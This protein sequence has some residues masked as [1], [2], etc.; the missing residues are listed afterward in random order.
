L[1]REAE[2][3]RAQ[4]ERLGVGRCRPERGDVRAGEQQPVRPSASASWRTRPAGHEDEPAGCSARATDAT[5]AK[6][7]RRPRS[8]RPRPR[9]IPG[10]ATTAGRQAIPATTIGP[11]ELDRTEEERARRGAAG[12]AVRRRRRRRRRRRPRSSEVGAHGGHQSA[13]EAH[14][15][16]AVRA[17]GEGRPQGHGARGGA[18]R[19]ARA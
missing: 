1:Q 5:P 4:I 3:V 18:P 7:R 2:R 10:R 16:V 14:R 6:Q 12:T 17:V 13:Y 19:C 8:S 9:P 15:G 11:R